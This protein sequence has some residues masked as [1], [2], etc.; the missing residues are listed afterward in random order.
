[1]KNV[2]DDSLYYVDVVRD[3]SY[4]LTLIQEEIFLLLATSTKKIPYTDAG[5][6]IIETKLQQCL[7][8]CV[9]KGIFKAGFTTSVPKVADVP[10]QDK[11]DRVF[12]NVT[13][14]AELAGAMQGVGIRGNVSF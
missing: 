12:Q 4:A 11:I 5:A 8:I 14:K 2:F 9:S 1:L 10:I 13:F 7:S 6:Q 3:K